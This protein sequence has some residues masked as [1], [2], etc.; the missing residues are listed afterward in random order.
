[1]ESHREI[2]GGITEGKRF[3]F[4]SLIFSDPAMGRTIF[5]HREVEN[6]PHRVMEDVIVTRRWTI[7]RAL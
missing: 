4:T 1:V 7:Q 6:C 5:D 2:D 3:P